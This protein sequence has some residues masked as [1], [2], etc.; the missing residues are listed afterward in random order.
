[1]INYKAKT[2]LATNFTIEEKTM[3]QET[4]RKIGEW[5]IFF[6][7]ALGLMLAIVSVDLTY[8][9]WWGWWGWW[10]QI[11]DTGEF[12]VKEWLFLSA[13]I[14][15]TTVFLWLIDRSISVFTNRAPKQFI[16]QKWWSAVMGLQIFQMVVFVA[17]VWIKRQ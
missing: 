11:F 17:F 2:V 9:M 3:K 10:W 8:Q 5:I 12:G 15:F 16:P 4:G 6:A 14:F 1:M 13:S 7:R